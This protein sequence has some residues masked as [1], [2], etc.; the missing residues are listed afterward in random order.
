MQMSVAL[1]RLCDTKRTELVLY[2]TINVNFKFLF[3]LQNG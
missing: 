1:S 2:D 3:V